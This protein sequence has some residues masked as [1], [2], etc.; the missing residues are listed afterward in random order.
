[1]LPIADGFKSSAQNSQIID[2]IMSFSPILVLCVR[3]RKHVTVSVTQILKKTMM[4]NSKL[5]LTARSM[6]EIRV[7]LPVEAT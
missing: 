3:L 7:E 2:F 1:M 4:A 6:Q 5:N